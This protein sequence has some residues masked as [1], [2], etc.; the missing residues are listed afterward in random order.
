V[1][2]SKKS[3]PDLLLI[4]RGNRLA[5]TL[6]ELLVVIAII[7]ILVAL[8]LPAVQAAREA[9]RRSQCQN[10]LKQMGLAALNLESTHRHF[11]TGGWGWHYAGDPDRGYGD[12][13]P[14]GWCYSVLSYSEENTLREL[15][16]DGDAK[17]LTPQQRLGTKQRLESSVEMFVCPSR[18]GSGI[19]P[20]NH[21]VNYANSDR[22]GMVGRNDYAACGGNLTPASV[23]GGPTMGGDGAFPDPWSFATSFVEHTLPK[24]LT[25][26]GRGGTTVVRKGNGVVLALSETT[27]A[28]ITDGASNTA[29]AGEKFVPAGE[30][31][32]S[33]NIGNDQGWDLGYDVDVIRWTNNPPSSDATRT[34][35]NDND[36]L[37]FGGPHPGGCQMVF[38]DGSVHTVSYDVEQTVFTLLG[39]ISDGEVVDLGD[40]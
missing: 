32:T 23:F 26:S 28:Q 10:N 39:P 14:G 20:F 2:A 8:L 12:Q 22:P 35:N 36:H 38:C 31:E 34:F 4:P 3:S 11:P 30:Y 16:S 21:T 33:A 1:V 29:F 27:F 25:A 40:L 9:A 6:V 19:Y 18:R 13:Q 5:F 17:R 15:G 37:M 7:G 24:D